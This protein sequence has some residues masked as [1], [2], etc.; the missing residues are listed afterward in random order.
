M[1][2]KLEELIGLLKQSE[3]KR[4]EAE[5]E[6]KISEQ[7]IVSI[8]LASSTPFGEDGGGGGIMVVGGCESIC[9]EG[10]G[11]S[12]LT[13]SGVIGERAPG[14]ESEVGDVWFCVQFRL[15]PT[16]NCFGGMMLIFGL[17]EALEWKAIALVGSMDVDNG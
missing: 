8:E 11:V 12:N 16:N 9:G 3:L 10:D 1:E 14:D 6:L 4:K 15:N 13:S 7:Q 5:K 2:E 17:L